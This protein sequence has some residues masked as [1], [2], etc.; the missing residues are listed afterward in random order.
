M[1]SRRKT[2]NGFKRNKYLVTF[3]TGAKWTPLGAVEPISLEDRFIERVGNDKETVLFNACRE[4]SSWIIGR[5]YTDTE[6]NRE[7][8]RL[9]GRKFIDL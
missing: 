9:Y 2:G 8:M 6:R 1:P 3:V 4:F 7:L 5:V